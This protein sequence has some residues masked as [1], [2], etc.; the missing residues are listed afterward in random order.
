MCRGKIQLLPAYFDEDDPVDAFGFGPI[1]LDYV[2]RRLSVDVPMKLRSAGA[3]A[4]DSRMLAEGEGD[5]SFGI[6]VELSGEEE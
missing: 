6:E 5:A 2:G 3:E 1:K 4:S